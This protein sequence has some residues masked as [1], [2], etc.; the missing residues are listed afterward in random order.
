MRG[1]DKTYAITLVSAC[2]GI[3][4]SVLVVLWDSN[5]SPFHLWLDLVPCGLGISGVIN[6]TLIV[7]L[8]SYSVRLISY[9]GCYSVHDSKRSEGGRC[10]GHR[11]HIPFPGNRP[12]TWGQ[13]ECGASSGSP[14][15]AASQADYGT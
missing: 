7:S 5:T 4:A 1:T 15:G 6:S 9:P 12:S 2:F 14:Y 3:V 13:L 10:S 8:R 11:D